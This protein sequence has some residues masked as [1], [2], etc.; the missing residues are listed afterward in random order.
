KR[1]VIQIETTNYPPAIIELSG[2]KCLVP[3]KGEESLWAPVLA[4]LDE[5]NKK[6]WLL[7]RKFDDKIPYVLVPKEKISSI[8]A[9]KSVDVW[10]DFY[11]LYPDSGGYIE[12]SAV[13]FN[14]DRTYAIVYM[15]HSCGG[16]CGGGTYHFLQKKDG[17][18]M[19][20][21]WK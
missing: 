3:A 5:I 2:Q 4:A 21:E 8:F 10:A 18:W 16:L 15:G 17:K 14:A 11:K 6:P 19:P 12:M 1:L 7:Q 9:A 20:A 13:G